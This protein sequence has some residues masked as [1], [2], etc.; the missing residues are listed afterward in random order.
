MHSRF[1]QSA[2]RRERQPHGPRAGQRKPQGRL[3][4]FVTLRSTA[5]CSGFW[6]ADVN[7]AAT[8]DQY[9]FVVTN[10]TVGNLWRMDPYATRIIH[11][12][13]NLNGVIDTPS[14]TYDTPNYSTPAWN[15]LVI[16]EMHIRTFLP[17]DG[18]IR[19]AAGESIKTSD[20][21][22]IG[23]LPPHK[24]NSTISAT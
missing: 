22:N 2:R 16:Y 7:G 24:P 19:N 20:G 5:S 23:R 8:G 4:I 17:G 18:S 9:K 3:S 12:G 6:S 13:G 11:S 15:E 10:P 1:E 21:A 14:T